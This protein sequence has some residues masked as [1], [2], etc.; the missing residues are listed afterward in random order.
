MK[1][2]SWYLWV[3][4]IFCPVLALAWIELIPPLP[5]E[6]LSRQLT[7]PP[8]IIEPDHELDVLE[9]NCVKA[10]VNY[11][12]AIE[13]FGR[14]S[15]EAQA[16]ASDVDAAFELYLSGHSPNRSHSRIGY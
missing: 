8:E 2:L 3:S 13:K 7:V 6:Q 9:Q 4:C 10:M 12:Q 15:R 5:Q 1:K 11:N 14:S 16:A